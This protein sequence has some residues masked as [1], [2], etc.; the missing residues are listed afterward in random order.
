MLAVTVHFRIKPDHTQDFRTAVLRQATN[1]LTNEPQCRQFDVCF[2]SEHP[3]DVFL[4]EVYDDPAAFESHRQMPYFAEFGA[5]VADW[6][7]SK[8]LR[9]WSVVRP[10]A[11]K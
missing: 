11:S 10:A 7:D 4:Y 6:V 1:S 2:D 9:T 8:E 3:Q 5:T